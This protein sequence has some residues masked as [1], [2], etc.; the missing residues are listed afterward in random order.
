MVTKGRD[1]SLNKCPDSDRPDAQRPLRGRD[2][3]IAA[4]T[5]AGEES[6]KRPIHQPF[7][8]PDYFTICGCRAAGASLLNCALSWMREVR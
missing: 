2:T 6:S 1:S 7:H 3:G 5:L 4:E 8:Y